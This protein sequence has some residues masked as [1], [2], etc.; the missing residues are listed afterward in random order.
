MRAE[1]P[2]VFMGYDLL[3]LD[4][5]MLIDRSFEERRRLLEGLIGAKTVGTIVLS[6]LFQVE[7]REGVD[8]LFTAARERGNEGLLLK[9]KAPTNPASA[10]GPGTN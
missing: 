9:R 8:L 1:V 2:V 5:R 10:A 3:F 6:P 7:S 4:G